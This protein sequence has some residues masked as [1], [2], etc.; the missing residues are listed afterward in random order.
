MRN[1]KRQCM[2]PGITVTVFA[3]MMTQRRVFRN[4]NYAR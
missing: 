2:L 3:G 4:E 1:A